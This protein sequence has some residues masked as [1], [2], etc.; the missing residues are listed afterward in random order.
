MSVLAVSV[1]AGTGLGLSPAIHASAAVTLAQ[2]WSTTI[3]VG[4]GSSGPSTTSGEPLGGATIADLYGDGRSQVVVGFM[5]GS[6][7]VLDGTTGHEMPGWP[8]YTGGPI[9]TNPSVADLY[10]DGRQEVIAS[11]ESGR[12][13]VWNADG[14]LAAGWPQS[15]HPPAS[16]VPRGFFGGVAVGDLFHDGH[17][18]LVAAAWDQQLY[19]WRSDGSLLP[20]FP[21]H[22]YDTAWDTPALADLEHTGQLDIVV[23]FDSSGPPWD[24][25]PSGGEMWAFRPTGC[26][27]G[28]YPNQTSCQIPGWPKTFNQTPWSSPA[29]ADLLNNGTTDVVAGTGQNFPAPRG[30]YVNAWTANGGALGSW[31]K[32]TGGFTMSS[33]AVGDLLG[34]G[35]REV[36]ALSYDHVL[37][38]WDGHG[39]SLAGWPLSLASTYLSYPTVAPISATQNGVWI[40]DGATLEAFNGSG[41]VVLTAG[42]LDWG[43][44]AAPAIGYLGG[45]GLSAVTVDQTNSS[46]YSAWTVRAF[47]IPGAAHMLA[48]AWPTFHGNAQLSGTIEPSAT[49]GAVAATQSATKI[50]VSWSLDANSVAAHSYTLWVRDHATA[51]W[52]VYDRT[53]ATSVEFDG[54]PGHTY[55]LAV[56]AGSAQPDLSGGY[57][58]T[59]FSNTATFAYPFQ[60]M[61]AAD[62]HGLLHGGSSAPVTGGGSWPT[63]NVI[64]GVA[65]ASGGLGGYLLDAFGGLH[66]FGNAPAITTGP[67][68]P[69]W[70]I[71]RS[72]ALRADG[73]S[74]YVLDGWGALHPFG[75]SGDVPPPVNGTSWPGWDVARD[76]QLRADGQSGY[77]LDGYGGLHAFGA[78]ND[79]APDV[80][81]TGWWSGWDIAHRFALDA[82]GTGGYVMDGFGGLHPFGTAG[83]LPAPATSSSYWQGWDIARGVVFAPG[84]AAGYVVDAYGGMHPFNGVPAVSS[85]MYTPG[86]CVTQLAAG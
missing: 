38:V 62:G 79:M 77:T 22:V 68:W 41:Q 24:P 5:D 61:Y 44:F 34:N 29:A 74:G 50:T 54:Y 48:G 52:Q 57:A 71:A 47:A 45:G 60:G 84:S 32:A 53:S 20:G 37:H 27:V 10:G 17:Q 18:E 81:V 66:H 14:S 76:V 23:G 59:T 58:T 3:R 86:G 39:N 25:Y 55:D 70:D 8:Q 36:A 64:R 35:Q 40:I 19:G 13:Y 82:A 56:Q 80:T 1:A 78:T 43:G 83:N 4:A 51:T 11:S 9:H 42:G 85:Q 15:T 69:G 46:S 28:H 67:Y 16:N 65:V 6:V 73:H 12:V 75:T 33:P 31:P 7:S 2:T 63:W 72:V 49:L 21:I 26:P 30:W